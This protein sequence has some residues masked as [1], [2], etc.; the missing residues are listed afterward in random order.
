MTREE[1]IDRILVCS[2]VKDVVRITTNNNLRIET[3]IFLPDG[4][5]IVLFLPHDEIIITDFGCAVSSAICSQL[6]DEEYD[7]RGTIEL[8]AKFSVNPPVIFKESVLSH[9]INDTD[10]D[11][12]IL[13]M[14]I[15]YYSLTTS[16]I[17]VYRNGKLPEH[18]RV[19]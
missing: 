6:P 2:L 1:V 13:N 5:G 16:L 18:K 11:E 9:P 12:V 7:A 8:C 10:I 14:I 17:S 3:K 19:V 4:S 15:A